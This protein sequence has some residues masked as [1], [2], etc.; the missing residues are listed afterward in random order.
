MNPE[1]RFLFSPLNI[2]KL[3]LK[4]PK[5]RNS[6]KLKYFFKKKGQ[7]G[8]F[9]SHRGPKEVKIQNLV[10]IK[11]SECLSPI[12]PPKGMEM[13]LFLGYSKKKSI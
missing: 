13:R 3:A 1:D 4:M 7:L 5:N 12:H 11:F 10:T 8:I 2:C 6:G 9:N